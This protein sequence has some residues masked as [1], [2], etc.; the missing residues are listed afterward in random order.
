[1]GEV[2]DEE[3]LK[4]VEPAYYVSEE[5]FTTYRAQVLDWLRQYQARIRVQNFDDITRINL[6]NKTNPKYVLKNYLAQI[7]IDKADSGDYS[8]LHKLLAIFSNPYDEQS[9][10][11]SYSQKRPEWARDKAGCSMLSCSS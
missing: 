6:M 4:I 9:E 2:K 10:F 3:W 11:E 7:A 1:M 5:L 8:E